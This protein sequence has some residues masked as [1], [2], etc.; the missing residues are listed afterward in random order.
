MMQGVNTAASG[1]IA[2]EQWQQILANNLA[3]IDTIGYRSESAVLGSFPQVLLSR[4]GAQPAALQVVSMGTGLV[5]TVPSLVEGPLQQTG[6]PLDVAIQGQGFFAVQAPK[7][8]L[9]TRAGNF[10]LDAQGMLVT[11]QGYQVLSTAGTPIQAG[12]G[13]Q[14]N[15]NGTITYQGKT[16]GQIAVFS[17]TS[18]QIADVG[19]G[20]FQATGAVPRLAN[21]QLAPGYLEGSNVSAPEVLGAMIQVL[22]HFEA[23]QTF[24]NQDTTTLDQFIQVAS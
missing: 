2:D 7:G 11:P 5:A 22:R 6:Q 9:Y 1:M 15:P 13:A 19:G 24:L 3:Q 14:I 18:G 23:G 4:S 21:P 12:A 8:V 20:F 17:P 16:A 10:S